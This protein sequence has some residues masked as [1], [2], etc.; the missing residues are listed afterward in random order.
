MVSR[1]VGVHLLS[2]FRIEMCYLFIGKQLNVLNL[3]NHS[4]RGRALKSP[5]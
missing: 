5:G 1:S 2:D 4:L 3:K